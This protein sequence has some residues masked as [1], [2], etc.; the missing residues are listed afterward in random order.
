MTIIADS[1][2]PIALAGVMGG[3]STEVD[4]GTTDLFVEV[5]NFDPRRTR[6]TRR[7]AGLSTDASYRFERGVDVGLPPIALKRVAALIVA[8]AGGAVSEPPV[9]LYAG[10][11]P[12]VP[13]V[14]RTSRVARVLGVT[15]DASSIAGL[16][17]GLGCIAD[18]D[19]HGA[20]IHVVAPSWRRDLVAEAD[21]I[22]EVARLH[23]YAA[24]PD[25]IRPYRPGATTDAPLWTMAAR[26]RDALSGAGLLEARPT[27]FVSGGEEH[28]RVL[29]PL[30]ENEA[31]LRRTVLESLARRA[32]YNLTHMQGNVR[33]YEIGSA[34]QRGAGAL[35]DESMRVAL[36]VMG[37]RAPTHFTAAKPDA[38]DAWDAK[39][40]AELVGQVVAPGQWAL[41]PDDDG[42]GGLWTIEIG[43]EARGHV[44]RVDL[45]KPVWAS[46]AYGVELELGRVSNAD[47]APAGDHAHVLDAGPI[48]QVPARYRPLPT[49]PAAEFD[50]ALLVPGGV[51]AANVEQVIR[52]AAGDLLERLLVFDVYE[53]AGVE[54]GARSVAWRLTLRHPERTLR[55]KEIEGRRAKILSALQSELNVRQRSL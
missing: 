3:Q 4:A 6:T 51:T 22:E 2:D 1:K 26:L 19:D 11:A 42:A 47:V 43:G 18:V 12:H 9:D 32:E 15:L 24:L 39:G 54:E 48:H 17:K 25:E 7:A 37:Q 49:T 5:A 23:G 28:V 45:D 21:L 55:D 20:S 50:L 10:D 31:H 34:F 13:I 38:I 35:P 27:P 8:L 40:L 53:G 29:N 33:L 44:S 52:A 16:L 36:I 30:A 41:V 14:L 46:S